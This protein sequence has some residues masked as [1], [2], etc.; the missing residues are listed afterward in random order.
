M[1][2][3]VLEPPFFLQCL[4]FLVRMLSAHVKESKTVWIRRRGFRLQVLDSGLQ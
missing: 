3:L 4:I 2:K 1:Q